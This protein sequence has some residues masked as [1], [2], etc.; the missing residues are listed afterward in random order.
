MEQLLL[1][2]KNLSIYFDK[3][4]VVNNVTFT[5]NRGDCMALV[6]ESGSGKTMTAL[7]IM[8]LLPIV[9][10]VDKNSKVMM[11][12]DDLLDYTEKKM[13]TVRGVNV[14][15]IFQDAMSAFN[16][17]LTI[18]QQMLEVLSKLKKYS[19]IEIKLRAMSLLEK[20]GIHDPERCFRSY[21]HELSG[22]MRQRAMIAMALSGEPELIIADEPTTA[23]DV[24][25][26][27]QVLALLNQLRKKEKLALLFISH[28]LSVVAQLA[29]D[30]TVMQKGKVVEQVSCEAFFEKPQHP[31]SR[32]L[33][34]C[35]PANKARKK[36]LSPAGEK[37]LDVQE[38]KVYFPIRKGI[39]KRKV[40]DVKA[41]DEVSFAIPAGKTLALV[42]ES[43]SGKTTT[44]KA[45]IRLIRSTAGKIIF[46][47]IDL[48][49]LGNAKLRHCRQYFQ[50]I[51][52]DPYA[53]LNPRRMVADS[54]MEGMITQ[55][56][57][58]N[59]QARLQ[60]IDELL[61]KV[62]LLPE[63]K[64]RYPHEFSGGERQRIC[65]ARALALKP[66]LLILDE[67]TSALDVSIQMQVLRLLESL[68]EEEKIAF[69]LI[70]HNISVVAYLSHYLAVMYQGRIVEQGETG[71]IL[72]NPCHAYTQK[73]L[74]AV[75][76]LPKESISYVE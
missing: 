33:L 73:L 67:P 51:F 53:S 55:N 30:I 61:T 7:S 40:D 31:Y 41:V 11:H 21:A 22:G 14:G 39:L 36:V 52:Q 62:G 6:G 28:D 57:G 10:R 58:G 72:E 65:I 70:T 8:Q 37:L 2:I 69:L 18:G 1:S 19:R 50:V 76:S 27:A 43:G 34:A 16:P 3:T 5:L 4:P 25:I 35:I 60:R 38:L 12:D 13:R 49:A 26:Q 42:G 63:H 56:I 75:P 71:L 48:N 59:R 64:W 29:D 47:D 68:Q 15:M 23:L 44:A 54:I 45:I 9:A 17:V 46:D 74:S 66:K 32:Q 20:V 24:T